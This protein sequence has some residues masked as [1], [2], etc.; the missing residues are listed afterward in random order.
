L[1]EGDRP[2]EARAWVAGPRPDLRSGVPRVGGRLPSLVLLLWVME[3]HPRPAAEWGE[4]ALRSRLA[5]AW[6]MRVRQD[7]SH[8]WLPFGPLAAMLATALLATIGGVCALARADCFLARAAL[9]ALVICCPCGLCAALSLALRRP[10]YPL[11]AV[12]VFAG[13]ISAAFGAASPPL[14]TPALSAASF[15][16]ASLSRR[17]LLRRRTD[18]KLP[19]RTPAI[20]L[21]VVKT[22]WKA[23]VCLPDGTAYTWPHLARVE[24]G[25][26]LFAA[27]AAVA[28]V[29]F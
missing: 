14:V 22:S 26:A 23:A 8:G 20:T 17:V 12:L 2:I 1:Q 6:P 24:L 19:E 11:A 18:A 16:L 13:T 4:L 7:L 10:A 29:L 5:R 27:A 21:G 15:L 28:A 25:A 9:P 3:A